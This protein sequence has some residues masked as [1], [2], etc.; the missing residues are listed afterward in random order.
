MKNEYFIKRKLKWRLLTLQQATKALKELNSVRRIKQQ[1][2]CAQAQVLAASPQ[3]T[4]K[5]IEH[6]RAKCH[7]C[8]LQT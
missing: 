8:F 7:L 1:K 3:A 6:W 5:V 4:D 2:Q